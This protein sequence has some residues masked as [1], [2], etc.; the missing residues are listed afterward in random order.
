MRLLNSLQPVIALMLVYNP[1]QVML[2]GYIFYV[3]VKEA[4]EQSYIPLCNDMIP[5]R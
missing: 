3:I 5:V 4:Y 1:A 2:C